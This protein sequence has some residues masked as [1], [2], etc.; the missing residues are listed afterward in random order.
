MTTPDVG[1]LTFS[2][3]LLLSSHLV[4]F[5]AGRGVVSGEL[6]VTLNYFV[7]ALLHDRRTGQL[8]LLDGGV[9]PSG[10]FV[11]DAESGARST[12]TPIETGGVPSDAVFVPGT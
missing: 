3:D 5:E 11:F 6:H 1:Y 7:P 2:T 12:E 8:F 9:R 10:V 4:R